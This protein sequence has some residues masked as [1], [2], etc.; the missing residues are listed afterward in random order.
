[1]NLND[2]LTRELAKAASS[3]MYNEAAKLDKVDPKAV[4]G[5]FDDRE[6]K[7]IDND[8]DTDSSDEYLHKKRQAISKAIKKESVDLEEASTADI[9]KVLAAAKKAG[10]DVEGNTAD[11][12]QGAVV[13]VSIEKGK[14]KFDGGLSTGVEYFKNVKDAMM[15]FESVDLEEATELYK[16]GKITLTQFA[17]GKGKGA[18]LQINYGMKFIQ[19]PKEEIKQLAQGIAYVTKSVSP[20]KEDVELEEARGFPE[21]SQGAKAAYDAVTRLTASLKRGSNLNKAV[22]KKLEGN[23][24]PEFRKMEKAIEEILYILDEIDREYQT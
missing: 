22:N 12:G 23:Y 19:I 1:M 4:K 24:D 5:D 16:K 10:A 13:D 8:G 3:I 2:D 18:G 21:S 7:D 17:M 9:K 11:F 6:D 20:F 14:I 15:A